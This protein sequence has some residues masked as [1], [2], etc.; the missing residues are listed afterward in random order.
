MRERE[1]ELVFKEEEGRW[2]KAVKKD[3]EK[4]RRG[5]KKKR[6][7]KGLMLFNL[8]Q[9]STSPKRLSKITK[10]REYYPET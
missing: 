1:R 6:K 3:P 5:K 4:G 2:R 7:R 9:N 8:V 10:N